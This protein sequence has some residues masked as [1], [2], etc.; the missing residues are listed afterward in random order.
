[1]KKKK[2]TRKYWKSLSRG[3]RE[4]ALTAVF[5]LGRSTV[6]MLMAEDPGK[7]E[8]WK[9]VFSR[10]KIPENAGHYKTVVRNTYIP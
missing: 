2:M 3:S 5:P 6:E 4:R 9:I 10:V 7:G 1:M 8:W